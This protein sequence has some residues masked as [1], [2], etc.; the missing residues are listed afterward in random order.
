MKAVDA[1][2]GRAANHG[3]PGVDEKKGARRSQRELDDLAPRDGHRAGVDEVASDYSR[4]AGE[5]STS[6]QGAHA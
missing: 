2:Q 4:R 5:L 3:V 6:G 1:Q